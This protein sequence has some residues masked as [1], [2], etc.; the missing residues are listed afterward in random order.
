MVTSV[1]RTDLEIRSEVRELLAREIASGTIRVAVQGGHVV[2]TGRVP[3]FAASRA[4][5]LAAWHVPGVRTV[6]NALLIAS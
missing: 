5:E 6:T 3:A 2:L 1:A 4:A